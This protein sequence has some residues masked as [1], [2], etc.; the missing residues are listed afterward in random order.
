MIR[1]SGPDLLGGEVP[2][3]VAS[4]E[5][6]QAMIDAN[7]EGFRGLAAEMG[8]QATAIATAA[9]ARDL[10]AASELLLTFDG[11]CETCHQA[12]WYPRQ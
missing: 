10:G 9:E 7:P 2:E 8:R 5:Q 4:R 6:I 3:G 12:Y 11:A 1:A